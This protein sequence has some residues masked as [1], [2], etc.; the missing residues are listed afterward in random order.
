MRSSFT[1]TGGEFHP[2]VHLGRDLRR[3]HTLDPALEAL[4]KLGALGARE[5]AVRSAYDSGDYFQ[6]IKGG[7]GVGIRSGL[8]VGRVSAADFKARWVE[9]G[10]R[11]V[12]RDR[13]VIGVVRGKRVLTKGARRSGLRVKARRRGF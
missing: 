9:F 3:E 8:A 6:S 1:F 13:R 7:V 11:K 4:A 10:H 12:T 5:I 2:N